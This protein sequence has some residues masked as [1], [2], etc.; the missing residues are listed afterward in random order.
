MEVDN[1]EEKAW[2]CGYYSVI[3]NYLYIFNNL[4]QEK[5]SCAQ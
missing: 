2:I 4:F 5:V 3:I 1:F